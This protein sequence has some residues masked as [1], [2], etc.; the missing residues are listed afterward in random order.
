M[1]ETTIVRLDL[2]TGET[3]EAILEWIER[4]TNI[5]VPDSRVITAAIAT[6]KTIAG[7]SVTW[8]RAGK[9]N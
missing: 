8:T 5:D 9:T 1:K 3:N 6:D 7:V 2:T 4:K